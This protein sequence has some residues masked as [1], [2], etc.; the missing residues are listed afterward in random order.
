MPDTIHRNLKK[1]TYYLF[2]LT[3]RILSIYH[4]KFDLFR[5]VYGHTLCY[6]SSYH[7]THISY[8]KRPLS[9]M[10]ACCNYLN[11]TQHVVTLVKKLYFKD[12]FKLNNVQANLKK[13]SLNFYLQKFVSQYFFFVDT[14]G[15]FLMTICC[16]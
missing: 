7:T 15:H 3:E 14:N 2:R 8:N 16:Q 12:N 10:N 13:N 5:H 4:G 11:C 1:H 9:S 6:T